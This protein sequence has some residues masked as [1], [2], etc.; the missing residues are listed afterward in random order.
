MKHK[1]ICGDAISELK[2]LTADSQDLVITSPPYYGLRNYG[3]ENQI[4]LEKTFA[5]YLDKMIEI[6]GEI[7]RVVKKEG[8]IWI[9]FGSAYSNGKT[10]IV[11]KEW[12]D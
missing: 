3:V 5:E 11:I 1:I 7:K 2:K 6:M 8:Q 10:K 4:G 12:Y 9:N